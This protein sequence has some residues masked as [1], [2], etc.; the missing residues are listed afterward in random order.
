MRSLLDGHPRLLAWRRVREF[1]VPPTMIESTA[2]RL[3]AG[4]W[5]GA[6]AAARVD[7]ELDPRAIGRRHGREL[8]AEIRADLRNLVPDLLRWHFP[9][10]DSGLLRPGLTVSLARYGPRLHLVARTAPGWAD[11]DQR[12]SLALGDG[13]AD[14]RHPHPRPHRR[15]RLDL[16]RHLWDARRTAELADRA[17]ALTWPSGA[18]TGLSPDEMDG[19]ALHRWAAEADI[20]RFAEGREDDPVFVRLTA[21]DHRELT[22]SPSPGGPGAGHHG[23]ARRSVEPDALILPDAATWLLPDLELLRAGLIDAG[24]LHPLVAASL[25]PGHGRSGPEAP[26]VADGVRLV[27]CRGRQHR[28]GLVDGVLSALDHDADELVREEILVAFGGPP[29]ACLRV[30]E[31]ST[32]RPESLADIR[33]RLD[34]GDLAGALAAV[35]GLLGPGAVLRD[36]PLRDELVRIERRHGT[37]ERYRTA[38]TVQPPPRRRELPRRLRTT[39]TTKVIY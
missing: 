30:I 39:T 25:A 37:Y 32:R 13:T 4:D 1:A 21:R 7:P 10:V 18:A 19:C 27:E 15:F 34:H 29:V 33:A 2:A 31:Q 36:G 11:A 3:R 28:I 8:A 5:A 20:L 23:V 22:A 38:P 16:H 17:G 35:E 9:R 14:G 24:Q 12:I 26:G 6:C